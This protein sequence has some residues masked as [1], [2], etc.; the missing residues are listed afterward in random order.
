LQG[1]KKEEELSEED[2]ALKESL[3]LAGSVMVRG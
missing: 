3:E 1:E 2:K